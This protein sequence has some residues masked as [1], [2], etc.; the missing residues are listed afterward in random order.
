MKAV[1][2][3]SPKP[4]ATRP[5][6]APASC[7]SPWVL[8]PVCPIYRTAA[9]EGA[10]FEWSVAAIP[11][12]TPD[13]V[14][15]IYGASVSIPRT[16]PEGEL[17][18]CLF[19]K[20]YTDTEAQATWAKASEYFPVRASVADGLADYFAENPAYKTAFDMLEYG[21]FEPPTP[22][23][24]FVRTKVGEAMAAIADGADVAST[25]AALNEESNVILADQMTS[26]LPTPVPTE[27]PQ[28]HRN[29]PSR[30]AR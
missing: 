16:T 30:P 2:P 7:S 1:P 21:R 8:P 17:A 3:S 26:P 9:E 23:Y 15:N 14:M 18:A 20:H 5:I 27:V 29:L 22:G 19:I 28:N 10:N 12:T 4:M 6:S 11:H 13:P 25:L 24:D